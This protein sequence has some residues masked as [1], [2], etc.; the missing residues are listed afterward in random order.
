MILR[1][2]DVLLLENLAVAHGPVGG[3]VEDFH[4]RQLLLDERIRFAEFVQLRDFLAELLHAR[5]DLRAIRGGNLDARRRDG[6]HVIGGERDGKEQ[7]EGG[8]QRGAFHAG[9]L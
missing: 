6:A 3:L 7:C 8:K 4:I 1:D 2:G 5:L 9:V